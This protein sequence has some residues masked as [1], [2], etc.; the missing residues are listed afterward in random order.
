LTT[1]YNASNHKESHGSSTVTN[2]TYKR[3]VKSKSK[4]T[5][6]S[7]YSVYHDAFYV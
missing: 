1:T 7:T 3:N 2:I 4:A 6:E 5:E